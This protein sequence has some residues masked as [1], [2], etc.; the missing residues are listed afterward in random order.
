MA[1]KKDTKVINLQGI[2]IKNDAFVV[3][4]KTEWNKHIVDVLAKDCILALQKQGVQTE[5][6]TVPG[7]GEIPFIINKYYELV[8]QQEEDFELDEIFLEELHE[9]EFPDED[10]KYPDAFIALGCVIKGDTA[11]FDYVCQSVT[12]GITELNVKLPMPIINMVLAVNN[13]EQAKERIGGK[14]GN[15]GIEAA[16][17]AIKMIDVV[18]DL[19]NRLF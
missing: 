16:E 9:E 3:I 7:A 12:K 8:Q 18:K 6:L 17:T 1:S 14:A 4:V 10:F 19:K 13:E 11:H 2:K 5:I 15:K